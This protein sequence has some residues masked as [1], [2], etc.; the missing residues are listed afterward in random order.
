MILLG[1]EC[2]SQSLFHIFVFLFIAHSR[3]ALN[4]SINLCLQNWD[5]LHMGLLC[6]GE[7]VGFS[8][9]LAYLCFIYCSQS[10][11]T[12]NTA[13]SWSVFVNMG[14]RVLGVV[15]LGSEGQYL[16]ESVLRILVFCLFCDSH[17][18][19]SKPHD[20]ITYTLFPLSWRINPSSFLNSKLTLPASPQA[21]HR[22]PSLF[23]ACCT[24]LTVVREG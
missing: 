14:D 11:M 8:H 17:I 24:K 21:Y 10:S 4:I 7:N 2:Q 9:S 1:Y 3:L 6:L 15:L 19:H 18:S 22:F 5:I 23:N 13:V 16:A 20:S 12:R